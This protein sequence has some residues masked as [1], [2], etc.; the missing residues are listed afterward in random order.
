MCFTVDYVTKFLE[1]GHHVNRFDIR[2]FHALV[3]GFVPLDGVFL[4]HHAWITECA[5]DY[6]YF[7]HNINYLIF[8]LPRRSLTVSLQASCQ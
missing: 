5:Y 6:E 2:G 1:S 7:P 4:E 3:L 8:F